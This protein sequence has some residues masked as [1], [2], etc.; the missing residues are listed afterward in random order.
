MTTNAHTDAD[1]A[2]SGGTSMTDPY[3]E[4]VEKMKPCPEYPFTDEACPGE[5][6]TEETMR[7]AAASCKT[8]GGSYMVPVLP[9]LRQECPG[10]IIFYTTSIRICREGQVRLWADNILGY[11]EVQCKTCEGR[12]WVARPYEL[13][14][15][16]KAM[17]E[18]GWTVEYYEKTWFVAKWSPHYIEKRDREFPVTC[19]KAVEV[20]EAT[21]GEA[22]EARIRDAFSRNP[23]QLTVLEC[24]QGWT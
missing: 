18:A 8:C 16:L 15:L 10:E 4:L 14:L 9:G 3:T 21:V 24:Y 22:L 19:L 7:E 23:G 2:G 11:E 1:H 13:G 6:W 20:W 5:R 17:E 12:G